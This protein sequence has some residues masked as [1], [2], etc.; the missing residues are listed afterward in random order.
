MLE[1]A[2]WTDWVLVIQPVSRTSDESRDRF[3]LVR[4]RAQDLY[5][6]KI[7]KKSIVSRTQRISYD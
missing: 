4:S 2:T 1:D 6:G 3:M 7:G 5:E